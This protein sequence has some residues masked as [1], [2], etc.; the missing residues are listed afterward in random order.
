MNPKVGLIYGDSITIERAEEICK[1]LEAKG[2]ASTNIVLG[3][4]SYT[5]QYV[6]RDTD[7]YAVKSTYAEISGEKHEIFKKPKTDSGLKNSAKGL[8]SVYKNEN[9]F[10]LKQSATWGDVLHGEM[11]PVFING[12]LVK[13][14]SIYQIRERLNGF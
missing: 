3:I 14:E 11:R 1:R 6:T 2:F 10:A 13:E 9:G 12:H 5:Y 7:G 4:G 8:L